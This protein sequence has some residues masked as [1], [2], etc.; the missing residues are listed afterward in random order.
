MTIPNHVISSCDTGSSEIILDEVL[1]LSSIS[2]SSLAQGERT[3]CST[4]QTRKSNDTCLS[5]SSGHL[6]PSSASLTYIEPPEQH[7]V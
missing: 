1:S 2:D 6:Q 4:Q 3:S 7:S 5:H